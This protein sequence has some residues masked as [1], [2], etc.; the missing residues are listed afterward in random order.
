[1]ARN[2]ATLADPRPLPLTGDQLVEH[3]F[4]PVPDCPTARLDAAIAFTSDQRAPRVDAVTEAERLCRARQADIAAAAYDANT[5]RLGAAVRAAAVAAV[6]L[7][8]RRRELTV[9]D[10]AY[11]ELV[12]TRTQD[13]RRTDA[14]YREW[15][16]ECKQ[17]HSGWR[18]VMNR[19]DLE[20]VNDTRLISDQAKRADHEV[21][22][23]QALAGFAATH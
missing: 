6:E 3:Y 11:H 4:P 19:L 12:M 7:D 16:T 1:M 13:P 14:V 8:Q 2:A 15:I 5:D 22:R 20:R 18:E 10:D 23:T 17:I 9:L 21:R